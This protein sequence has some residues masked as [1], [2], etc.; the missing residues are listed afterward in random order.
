MGIGLVDPILPDA[1]PRP[2]RDAER[3]VAAV[4]LLLRDD[5]PLD[6]RQRLGR[7]AASARAARCSSASSL[8]VALQ[9]ARG[10]RGSVV[11]IAGFRLGWGLGNA[12]FIATALS[13]IVGAASRRAG[14]RDHPLRGRARPRHRL[15]PAARRPARRHLVARPVLRHRDADGDRLRP[16]RRDARP[17]AQ[18]GARASRSTAPLR[19]L[20]H[21]RPA[22]DGDRR[23]PLQL[24]LLHDPRLHA[25]P[26]RAD[27]APARPRL[28]R[29]GPAA[30]ADL[31]V[32]RAAARA[33]LRARARRSAS[34]SAGVAADLLA[35]GIFIDYQ[36]GAD[37]RGRGR[38]AR[39]SASSTPCSTEAVMAAAVVERPIASSAY[40]FVRFTGGAIAPFLAGKLAEHV[41]A[42]APMY[43]GA[44]MVAAVGRRARRFAPPPAP[45][46]APAEVAA[47][48][49]RRR[50]PRRDRRRR[51][52]PARSSTPRVASPARAAR[53]SMS[54]TCA[55]R[56]SSAA[57]SPTSRTPTGRARRRRGVGAPGG[58]RGHGRGL[59]CRR[60]PRGCRRRGARAR[61]PDRS[62]RDRRRPPGSSPRTAS[63]RRSPSTRPATW[64][65]SRAPVRRCRRSRDARP[66][67]PGSAR[68]AWRRRWSGDPRSSSPTGTAGR[69]CRGW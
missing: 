62:H 60:S 53:P 52:R 25:V 10:R 22:L 38:P 16:D 7:R 27:G 31:G 65:S 5:R 47:A 17:G 4:H 35:G 9:R 34:R 26:A 19:A 54:S 57:R 49:P 66:A 36:A 20:R 51:R 18:A 23:R 43:V 2:A 12:L 15:R 46:E 58:P 45:C 14:E 68:R 33:P 67:R 40:S 6:A 11:E 30:R 1:R 21:R 8:V 69:R 64:S 50:G 44:A 55:R 3:G 28:L 29:L 63:R 61:G 42:G 39:C 13:V 48:T 56:A 32:R 37:R 59:R 41:S 24:R